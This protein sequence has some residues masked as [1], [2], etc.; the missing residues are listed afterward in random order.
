ML[1]L[2]PGI[3]IVFL[4]A[5]DDMAVDQPLDSIMQIPEGFPLPE[6]PKDNEITMDR[7]LLGKRLFYDPVMSRDMT[8]S[9]S[10]CHLPELAFTDAKK[11]SE[12]IED[13]LGT[14]NAPTLANVA[15]HPYYTR[16]GGVPTLEMQI[17][18][19]IQEHAEFDFN[20][21]LIAE[22]LNADST[23]VNASWDAYDRAPDPFVITRAISCFER[24]LI[25]GHSKYDAFING[26]GNALTNQEVSGKNLFFSERLACS[27]CHNGFNF[28]N[29]SFEN[30]GLYAEYNDSGRFRLTGDSADIALF[31]VPTLRN[32]AVSA[33]YMHDGSVSSLEDVIDHYNSGGNNH[34][35]QSHFVKPLQL[36]QQEKEDLVAFLH[37]LTDHDF[38]SNPNFRN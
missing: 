8:L 24:S 9:C 10:S 33:P 15:Y 3:V 13:R 11:I 16:E 17:L 27:Q 6:Y 31:K 21:L 28:T 14:R 1:K 25:S 5:C 19:P 26:N 30:N 37:T 20:I 38:L 4:L 7:W 34:N 29:Y 35:H 32:I 22:R 36:S 2:I 23:Y 18:V 12:G